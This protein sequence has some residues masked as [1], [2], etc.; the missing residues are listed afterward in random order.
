MWSDQVEVDGMI[1][2][3]G[4]GRGKWWVVATLVAGALSALTVMLALAA[5]WRSIPRGVTNLSQEADLDSYISDVAVS[6]DGDRVAVV[7]VEE[8]AFAGYGGSVWLRWA[9]ESTGSG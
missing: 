6:L 5:P 3:Q 8:D 9:S 2:A 4:A 1:E 7:W